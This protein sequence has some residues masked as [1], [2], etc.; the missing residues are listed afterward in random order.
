M[1]FSVSQK[2]AINHIDGPCLVLAVPGAGKTTILIER[3]LNLIYNHNV[4]PS[5]ILALTFTRSSAR[6]MEARISELDPSIKVE[7][8]K[9]IHSLCYEILSYNARLTNTS[10]KMIEDRRFGSLRYDLLNHIKMSIDKT[11]LSIEDYKN[12]LSTISAKKTFGEFVNRHVKTTDIPEFDKYFDGYEAYK[13]AHNIL[14]YDD[15]LINTDKLLKENTEIRNHYKNKFKYISLDEAQDTSHIQW[16]IIKT[17]LTKKQNLFA[18]A[19]D[20]QSIYRFRGATPEMLM[21]FENEFLNAK[22]IYL[23]TNYRSRYEIVNSSQKLI[24]NNAAR[25]KKNILANKDKSSTVKVRIMKNKKSEYEDI[26]KTI[27]EVK[28]EIA[29]IYRNN[30]SAVALMDMLDRNLINFELKDHNIDFFYNSTYKDLVDIV[31]F[32]V[33]PEDINTYSRIYYKMNGFLTKKEIE[34]LYHA[35]GRTYYD[36][37][38]QHDDIKTY[39]KELIKDLEVVRKHTL[40]HFSEYG[41]RTILSS[42]GYFDYLDNLSRRHNRGL[43]SYLKYLRTL[44]MIAKNCENAEDFLN[45]MSDIYNM[46]TRENRSK[47]KLLSMHSSKGL[48]FDTVLLIDLINSEIPGDRI[49]KQE[50]EEERRLLYVGM[51]RAK[52]NL[53]MYSY[54]ADGNE[55]VQVSQFLYELKEKNNKR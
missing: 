40:K 11:A 12:I 8:I 1:Q 39:K 55:K 15:L 38:I 34:M 29:I 28:G 5:E 2:N 37:I 42:T 24:K 7:N 41:F 26:V 3:I 36:K 13:N 10:F 51:T 48:E 21:N 49:T 20:D 35:P 23:E 44:E 53:Y 17:L 31:T 52:E 33:N 32:F 19:D 30:I 6:D 54:K 16:S 4:L 50:L 43:E 22:I 46:A 27:K 25:F 47:I 9:T 45:R 14:D 18:V